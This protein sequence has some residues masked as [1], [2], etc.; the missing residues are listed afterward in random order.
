MKKKPPKTQTILDAFDDPNLF[1]SFLGDDLGSWSNWR[2]PLSAVYGLPTSPKDKKLIKECTGRR[3]KLLPADGFSQALFLTGRRSGKSR[4]ASIIGAYEACLAGHESKL[5][6]GEKGI[7]LIASPTKSQ[8]RIVH[9]YCRGIFETGYLKGQV[10]AETQTGFELQNGIRIEVLAGSY[11]YV[12]GYTL[13][14]AILDEAAF[15]GYSEDSKVKSDLELVRAI[16]PSLATVGGKLI[17]ISSPYA[18]K[19]WCYQQFRKYFGNDAGATLIWN[20]PSRTMNP[21]LSQ[22]IID[23]AMQ[24]DPESAAAEYFGKFRTELVAFLSREVIEQYVIKGRTELAPQFPCRYSCF[25]DLSGG[26]SDDAAL[27]IAHKQDGKIIIDLLKRWR[28]PFSPDAVVGDMVAVCSRYHISRVIG[29]NYSAEFTKSAFE[30]RGIKYAR[31]TTN[32]WAQGA[33]A[34]ITKS[35][36]QL[37]LEF[38]PRLC[39][40]E[41]E[42]LDSEILVNQLAGLERRTRSGGR[43]SVDHGP[44]QHDDVANVC[45]GVCDAVSQKALITVGGDIFDKKN[46]GI[47]E[48]QRF[49][50]RQSAYKAHERYLESLD[51][52]DPT[53]IIQAMAEGRLNVLGDRP[54]LFGRF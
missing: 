29:D 30:T 36:S 1:G 19:G 54:N 13:V 16:S 12:R 26:R 32:A 23:R 15:L 49:A 8:S 48:A 2:V 39:S 43:D 45:A 53:G 47:S 27:A 10:V 3:R 41:V 24:D 42:L 51:N 33:I 17:G 35:K 14:A 28:P 44:S 22:V 9:G 4:I 31:A 21:T 25:V 20:C 46:D 37:Y 18:E 7:V 6:K 5:A 40:G 52:D 50:Q 34:K 38:L 11:Q